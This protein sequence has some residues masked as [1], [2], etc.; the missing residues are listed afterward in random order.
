MFRKKKN[1]SITFSTFDPYLLKNFPPAYNSEAMPDWFKQTPGF[2]GEGSISSNFEPLK[3][4]T[5]RRCPAITDYFLN[6]LI[7]P[8]WTDIEFFVDSKEKHLE[9]RYS[10][11]YEGIRLV[12]P[13]HPGQFPTLSNKYLHAKII[14]PWIADCTHNIKWLQTMP[15][16]ASSEFEDQD[17]VFLDGVLNY[18]NNFST[19]VNLF[20]PIRKNNYSVKFS[21]GKPFQK[22]IPLTERPINIDTSYC[23]REYYSEA[24]LSGRRISYYLG[25]FYNSMKRLGE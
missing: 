17:V 19:H 3:G 9:W 11:N 20:F 14:S 22:L 18:K 12:Q 2:M 7:I 23:T 13:H 10:N 5:I 1:P 6:G 16:Y 4:P 21:A 8:L 24:S 25:K 15:V